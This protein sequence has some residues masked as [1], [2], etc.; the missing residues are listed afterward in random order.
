MVSVSEA[1]LNVTHPPPITTQSSSKVA[2]VPPIN[3]RP[4]RNRKSTKRDDFFILVILVH[5]LHLLLLY[6]LSP[7]PIQKLFVIHFGR[8]K[9]KSDGSVERYKARLVAKGYSQ[10]YGMDYEETFALMA[11]MTT[12]R[13]LIALASSCQW[14]KSQIDVKNVFLNGD[15]NEE[16]Y[17]KPPPGIP[18]KS[19]EVC[20]LQKALYRLKQAPRA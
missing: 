1:T 7:S 16:V 8:I 17:M 11:K 4:I 5:L 19:D 14:K 6:M 9:N 2:A 18:Y 10:E 13:N 20:K 3:V 12:V 15:L